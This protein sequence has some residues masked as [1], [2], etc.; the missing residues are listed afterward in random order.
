MFILHPRHINMYSKHH[1]HHYKKVSCLPIGDAGGEGVSPPTTSRSSQG[2]GGGRS[3]WSHTSLWLSWRAERAAVPACR[4]A[5]SSVEGF[6]CR[7]G[8]LGFGLGLGARGG[9]LVN[10]VGPRFFPGWPPPVSVECIPSATPR[11]SAGERGSTLWLLLSHAPLIT[12]DLGNDDVRVTSSV[13]FGLARSFKLRERSSEFDG[14]L[15]GEVE[16][17]NELRVN[18]DKCVSSGITSGEEVLW[19][20]W[21]N[22]SWLWVAVVGVDTCVGVERVGEGDGSVSL[23]GEVSRS[24]GKLCGAFRKS[25]ELPSAWSSSISCT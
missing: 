15:D 7:F 23:S 10:C 16:R 4:L 18:D 8:T 5:I 6:E 12:L 3:S 24:R 11:A 25:E 2:G 9:A 21:R 19:P 20:W 22:K 1:C 14:D 13:V 17:L